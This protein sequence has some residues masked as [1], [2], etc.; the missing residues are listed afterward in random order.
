MTER[1]VC[2]TVVR[3]L[4]QYLDGTVPEDKRELVAAHLEVCVQCAAHFD[5]ARSFLDA[6]AASPSLGREDDTLR[7]RVVAA[8]SKEGFGAQHDR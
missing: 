7:S 5:F 1:S 6:V 3:Q 2:E 8:L 4:W